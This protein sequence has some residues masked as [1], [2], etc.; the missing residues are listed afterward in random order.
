V[1]IE[2]TYGSVVVGN[3]I[4]ECQG[5]A[6]V[7]D[8]DC[9]GITLSANVIAH[10]SG[11]G[12]DLRDAHGCAVSANT[13]TIVPQRA[14]TIGP[15]SGR[16]TVSANNFS[17]SYIG[18]AEKREVNDQAASGIV[19]NGASDIAISGNLFSGLDGEAVVTDGTG[20]ARVLFGNNVITEAGDVPRNLPTEH[21]TDNLVNAE[22]Q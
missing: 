17:D 21:V 8:R 7:L 16:I 5:T 22:N 18:D 6:I 19:L 1:V 2:N 3:M 14:V 12:I 15:D 11:G 10:D 13:F 9:Y 20:A 4:E